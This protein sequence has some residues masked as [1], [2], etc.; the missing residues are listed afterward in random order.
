[1]SLEKLKDLRKRRMEQA[2]IAL[3]NSKE[4]LI[5]C[6]K[7]LAKKFH[8]Q[9]EYSKW[10]LKHQDELFGDL[11]SGIFAPE[12]LGNYMADI[13]HMKYRKKQLEDDLNNAKKKYQQAEKNVHEKQQALSLIVKKLEK[14][15]EIIKMKMEGLSAE[16]DRREENTV[17]EIVAFRASN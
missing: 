4:Y 8:Q 17:D 13:E 9:R 2:Y 5:F 3:Q 6:E 16:L 10:R 11:Q 1:M 7:D 14:L 12:D 15:T